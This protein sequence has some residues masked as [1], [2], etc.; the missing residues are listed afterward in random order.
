MCDQLENAKFYQ[1]N[2][3]SGRF[4]INPLL[5]EIVTSSL[6]EKPKD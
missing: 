5:K 1:K 6:Q 4:V 2:V 3:F